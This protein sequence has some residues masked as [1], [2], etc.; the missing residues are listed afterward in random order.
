MK[1]K[2]MD[3]KALAKLIGSIGVART[4]LDGEVQH[5]CVQVIGQSVVHRNTTPANSLLDAV[6]K[7]HKATVVTYLERFGNFAW[8]K[9]AER[10]A[11]LER[12]AVTELELVI[13]KIG[14]AKWYDARKPAKVV[15]QYD[16]MQMLSDFFDRWFKVSKKEGVTLVNKPIVDAVYAAYCENVAKA[17]GEGD[18]SKEQQAIDLALDA[19][20]KGLATPAQLRMLAEHYGKPV[21][22]H[23]ETPSAKQEAVIE[24]AKKFGGMPQMVVNQ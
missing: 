7:H 20:Q 3:G 18:K 19:R 11:F 12:F 10:L 1:F 22:L 14:D 16:G 5:A 8:E 23:A 2:L 9:K 17:Y 24:E 15:S 13:D 6:S 4:K 21:T